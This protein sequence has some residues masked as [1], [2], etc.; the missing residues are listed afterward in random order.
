MS[1]DQHRVPIR[2]LVVFCASMIELHRNLER[3]SDEFLL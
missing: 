2:N 3:V 1:A